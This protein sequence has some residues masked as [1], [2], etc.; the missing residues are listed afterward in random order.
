MKPPQSPTMT[1]W[2]VSVETSGPSAASIAVSGSTSEAMRRDRALV[3]RLAKR[4]LDTQGDLKE[5]AR[6]L[7][8][9]N[10]AWDAPRAKLKRPGE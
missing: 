7:V 10:D 9:T 2:R 3:D 5:L 1:N 8:A 6:L 4:F